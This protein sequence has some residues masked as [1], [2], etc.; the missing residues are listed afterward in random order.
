M[1]DVRMA[2]HAAECSGGNTAEFQ[3]GEVREREFTQE[4]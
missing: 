3:A 2:E 4:E 1:E